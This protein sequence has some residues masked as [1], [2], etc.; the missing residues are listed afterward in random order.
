MLA[1]SCSSFCIDEEIEDFT[2]DGTIDSINAELVTLMMFNILQNVINIKLLL[3]CVYLI[4]LL[5]RSH[6]VH[7]LITLSNI[8]LAALTGIALYRHF[9]SPCE[10]IQV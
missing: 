8:R 2:S 5:F 1:D 9:K 3:L 7:M 4:S 10:L 6:V